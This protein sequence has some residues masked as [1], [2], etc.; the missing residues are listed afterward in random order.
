MGSSPFSILQIPAPAKS[1]IKLHDD[2]APVELHESQCILFWEI[3]SFGT[4]RD[5]I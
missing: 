2:C 1:L 3:G 4:S 5:S